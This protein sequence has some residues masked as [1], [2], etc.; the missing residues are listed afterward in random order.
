MRTVDEGMNVA[1]QRRKLTHRIEHAPDE[2]H[3]RY[4]SYLLGLFDE[5]VAA[6]NPQPASQFLP[7]YAEEFD[8]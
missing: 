2:D 8:E 5:A 4:L 6:G 3:A 1:R 7:M